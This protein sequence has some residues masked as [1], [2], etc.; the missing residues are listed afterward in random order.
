[1]FDTEGGRAGPE[2]SEGR[3]A[4]RVARPR[5]EWTEQKQTRSAPVQKG[6]RFYGL[7]LK[8]QDKCARARAGAVLA[9]YSLLVVGVRQ[10]LMRPS[11]TAPTEPP[12]PS[13]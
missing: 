4:A 13:H 1:M 6:V 8:T 5:L 3:T 2:H 9:R 10:T 12:E 7:S 11:S